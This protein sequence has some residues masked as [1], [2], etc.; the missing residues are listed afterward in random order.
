MKYKVHLQDNKYK[1]HLY[2]VEGESDGEAVTVAMDTAFEEMPKKKFRL[3]ELSALT[4]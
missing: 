1:L 3:V 2:V 4:N